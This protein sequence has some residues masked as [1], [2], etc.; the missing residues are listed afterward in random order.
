MSSVLVLS[1]SC[2]GKRKLL[3]AW[4]S[5]VALGVRTLFIFAELIRACLLKD[6]STGALVVSKS[7]ILMAIFDRSV[8]EQYPSHLT[9]GVEWS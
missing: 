4:T 5:F 9:Q 2:F 3:A 6:L 8:E 7:N 1:N